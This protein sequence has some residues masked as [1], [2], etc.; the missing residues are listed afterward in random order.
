M[1]LLSVLALLTKCLCL[2]KLMCCRFCEWQV[3]NIACIC[4]MYLENKTKQKNIL[5]FVWVESEYIYFYQIRVIIC[6]FFYWKLHGWH[7]LRWHSDVLCDETYVLIFLLKL[8]NYNMYGW[9]V[10]MWH[11]DI[12]CEARF[13]W[14][15]IWYW[16]GSK[17]MNVKKY[18]TECTYYM[19][20]ILLN[21]S[22]FTILN[23]CKLPANW[24]CD[25][26]VTGS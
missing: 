11:P 22:T 21:S 26:L 25:S 20:K 6:W 18:M 8:W 4:I 13:S 7:V 19:S 5:F 3:F 9:H 10:L 12:L 23:I 1:Q 14:M 15:S 24:L 17:I 16:T 2:I